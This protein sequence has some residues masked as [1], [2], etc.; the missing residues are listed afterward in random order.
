MS[1]SVLTW[2]YISSPFQ[3]AW[4]YILGSGPVPKTFNS[5]MRTYLWDERGL[6][7]FGFQEL[8]K[9]Y[10]DLSGRTFDEVLAKTPRSMIDQADANGR[11]VLSWASERGDHYT[12]ARLLP[13][14]A[15]PDIPDNEG[16]SPLHRSLYARTVNCMHLLLDAKA[17]IEAKDYLDWTPLMFAAWKHEPSFMKL[18]LRRGAN[19]HASDR[20]EST[21]LHLA[22]KNDRVKNVEY[23]L[24][25][26]ADI[27]AETSDGKNVLDTAI[28]YN[29]HKTLGL[30]PEASG[31]HRVK[32]PTKIPRAIC[33]GA[34]HGDKETLMML[35]QANVSISDSRND[36]D[37]FSIETALQIAKRRRDDNENMTQKMFKLTDDDPGAWFDTFKI[38]YDG[39]I[40]KHDK[41]MGTLLEKEQLP[42]N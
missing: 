37:N 32:M 14:G 42:L 38:L 8:H 28:A 39:I 22:V 40:D 25:T 5:L 16:K 23:L 15:D 1:V 7:I 41:Q 34:T 18:L 20:N 9:A 27:N 17:N 6:E 11:T 31:P 21:G 2:I 26:G 29:S 19:I 33:L 36:I 13:L 24:Q 12:V 4:A 35:H 3:I 30:L 10:L